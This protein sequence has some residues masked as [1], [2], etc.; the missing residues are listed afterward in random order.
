MKTMRAWRHLSLPGLLSAV[1]LLACTGERP[2]AKLAFVDV[3]ARNGN[4]EVTFQSD[5]QFF[6]LFSKNRQQ[7]PVLS[8]LACA[9][10]KVAD[11]T[12]EHRPARFAKGSI[13]PA[14]AASQGGA[15]R[16]KSALQFW[17]SATDPNGSDEALD[18]ARLT[19]TL[20]D[21]QSIPCI[22]RMTIHLSQPYYTR[23]MLVPV[24][25]ILAAI[26]AAAT[27]ETQ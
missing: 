9:L 23:P 18:D 25:R 11:L 3:A 15:Y 20:A 17:R 4:V 21:R 12:F 16:F 2:P 7:R 26:P 8:E 6:D 22:V 27:T 1:L 24:D 19:E 13:E 5:L 14:G 10:D